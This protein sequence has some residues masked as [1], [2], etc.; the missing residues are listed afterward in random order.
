[1]KTIVLRVTVNFMADKV[2]SVT[3]KQ[4]VLLLQPT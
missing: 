2:L 1:M 3:V 4:Q